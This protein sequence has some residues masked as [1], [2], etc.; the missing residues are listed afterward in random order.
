MDNILHEFSKDLPPLVTR[1]E[2]EKLT[3]G[4]IKARTL[5]NLDCKGKGPLQKMRIGKKV[6]YG[7][8]AVL[9]WLLARTEA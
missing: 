7:K 9:K 3:G 5:A 6:A 4:L 8:E 1:Q 2:L